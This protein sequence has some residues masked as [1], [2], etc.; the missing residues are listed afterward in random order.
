MWGV[1]DIQR[2]VA[3]LQ[4]GLVPGE[5]ALVAGQR[6]FER[7]VVAPVVP[8]GRVAATVGV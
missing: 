1:D 3:F 2:I 8:I 7:R 4:M 6:Q 5:Q